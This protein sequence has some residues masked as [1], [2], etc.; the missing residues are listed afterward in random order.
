MTSRKPSA[1]SRTCARFSIGSRRRWS[2]RG[3]MSNSEP[4]YRVGVAALKHR[5]ARLRADDRPDQRK[6]RPLR[7]RRRKDLLLWRRGDDRDGDDRRSARGRKQRPVARRGEGAQRKCPQRVAGSRRR[8]GIG[9][10]GAPE[11]TASATPVPSVAGADAPS[12][13]GAGPAGS[14]IGPAAARAARAEKITRKSPT[15]A[16]V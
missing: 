14:S 6:Q 7:R 5:D 2:V 15:A 10:A 1:A 4:Q 13:S 16:S 3:W 12:T 9:R 8:A 11:A